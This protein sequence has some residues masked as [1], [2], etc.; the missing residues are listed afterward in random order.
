[1]LRIQ[2]ASLGNEFV[3]HVGTES[4]PVAG[5]VESGWAI[6][7]GEMLALSVSSGGAASY[8]Y[9]TLDEL[10]FALI[11]LSLAPDAEA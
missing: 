10:L 7:A 9:R 8:R 5:S 3:V 2:L 1:M 6:A 11:N 4:L